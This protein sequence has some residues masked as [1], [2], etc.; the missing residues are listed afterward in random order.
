MDPEEK[1]RAHPVELNYLFNNS[2]K[3]ADVKENYPTVESKKSPNN[4]QEPNTNINTKKKYPV[5]TLKEFLTDSKARSGFISYA[6]LR[7]KMSTDAVQMHLESVNII[8]RM[9]LTLE[10]IFSSRKIIALLILLNMERFMDHFLTNSITDEIFPVNLGQLSFS[11]N[12]ED[13]DSFFEEQWTVPFQFDPERHTEL[14]KGARLPFLSTP[15]RIA[16]GGFGI[17][18]KVKVVDGTIKYPPEVYLGTFST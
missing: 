4:A 5:V 13:S 8:L 12:R 15:K 16:R 1:E 14:P 18:Y 9:P 11:P 17:I 2:N 6:K 7:E 10:V 3:N